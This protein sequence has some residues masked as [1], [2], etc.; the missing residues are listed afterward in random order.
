MQDATR[1]PYLL[2]AVDPRRSIFT[3]AL[4]YLSALLRGQ[5][6]GGRV[7][8]LFRHL[9]L[10]SFN[11]W[12][13][14]DANDHRKFLGELQLGVIVAGVG[15][16]RRHIRPLQQESWSILRAG[17]V[18]ESEE[19]RLLAAPQFMSKQP[20]CLRPGFARR[21]RSRVMCPREL[22]SPEMN[23]AFQIFARSCR[24]GI[25]C[26]EWRHAWNRRHAT[27]STSCQSLAASYTTREATYLQAA[28]QQRQ[29]LFE[30]GPAA[31]L[32]PGGPGQSERHLPDA[33]VV[34]AQKPEQ[35]T[36]ASC[37]PIK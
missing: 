25:A 2:D 13:A 31:R 36:T 24:L 26:V 12:L 22:L 16:F 6:Q 15:I 20:C 37:R 29:A 10:P 3:V 33:P 4:Q 11:A 19:T 7:Q 9:G 27:Q 1:A 35:L 30:A 5:S 21:L 17:D 8:F 34:A 18:R 14:S 28:R 32:G 23:Q